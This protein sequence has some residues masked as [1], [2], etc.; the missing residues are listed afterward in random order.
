MQVF[1]ELLMNAVNAS[2][3]IAT[4]G[5]VLQVIGTIVKA[6]VPGVKVGE[7]C[8]LVNP[9]SSEATLAEVVGF[10]QEAALLTPLG[11]LNGV[12]SSTQVIPSGKAHCVPVGNALLGRV[13]NGLGLVTDIATKGP[14]EPEAYYPVYADP[15]NAM[16]RNPH[17]V[18]HLGTWF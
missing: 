3:P 2:T 18:L 7:L 8:S 5:K 10:V 11:E 6:F 13:L 12:S 15:P 1:Q 17:F 4:K 9:G 14:F 16:S